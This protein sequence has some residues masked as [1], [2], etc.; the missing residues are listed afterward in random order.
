VSARDLAAFAADIARFNH[1][2][3]RARLAYYAENDP[4]PCHDCG[5]EVTAFRT[6][7]CDECR[8]QRKNAVERARRAK[9]KETP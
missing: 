9:T 6:S 4:R 7:R 2:I 8:R 3:K 1:G 5:A